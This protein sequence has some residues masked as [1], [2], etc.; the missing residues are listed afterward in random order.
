MPPAEKPVPAEQLAALERLL[1]VI[2]TLRSPGG[3]DWDRKQTVETLA[4][5]LIEECHEMADA[6]ARGDMDATCGELGDLLMGVL[7]VCRVASEGRGFDLKAAAE[8][9]TAKLI[10]RHPHVYAETAVDGVDE[11]LTNWEAI[12]KQE[13]A[14]MGEDESA[15]SGVPSSLP[16][17]LRAHRVGQKA[18]NAGFDWPDLNGP[19]SKIHEEV[20]EFREAVESGERAAIEHEMGDLLFAVVNVARKAKVDPELALRGT[21]ERF[22]ARFRY[23]ETHLGKPLAE[24]TLAEM[25]ALWQQA[26]AGI[27]HRSEDR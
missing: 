20:D 12:K 6:V 5:H 27:G 26:K 14:E 8:S 21:I 9:I 13:R 22:E 3:C 25:E 7:M 10:R 24:A 23:I 2:D 17:L 15:L 18:S 1:Q 19:F 4:P 16:A 11:I